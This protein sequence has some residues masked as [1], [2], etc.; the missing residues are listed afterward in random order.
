MIFLLCIGMLGHCLAGE[1]ASPNTL[2]VRSQQEYKDATRNLQPGDTIV[3]ANGVWR[4][5]EILLVGE[6]RAGNPI[7]LTAETKGKVVISGESNLRLAGKHLVVSGLVFKDGHTP[8]DAVISFRRGSKE[9]AY[10]SRVTEVVVDHFNNPERRETDFWVAMYGNHNRFDHNHLV[11]KSNVGVT[12]A[13][14][15][16]T[17]ESRKNNHRIDHNYFGPRP[18]LGSNGGETLRIGTSHH[19]LTES[20]TLVENNYF[21]RCNGELEIISNKSGGNIFRG[22][23]FFE[24]RGTLTLRH[25]SGNLVESNV[26]LGNSVDHTGGIRVINGDQTIR[27]NYMENLAGYRFGGALVVM[28]GVPDS[29]INRYHQVDNAVIENNTM[30]NADHVQLAAGSDSERSAVPINSIFRSNLFYREDGDELF[31]VFD[32]ISGIEF[33]NNAENGSTEFGRKH[34]FLGGNVYLHRAANG[35]MYPAGEAFRGI[36]V[37]RDLAPVGKE[38]TGVNWYTKPGRHSPFSGGTI[39]EVTPAEDSLSEAIALANAGDELVLQAGNYRVNRILEISRP[40]TI[41]AESGGRVR[42][43]YERSALFEIRDGGSLYLKGLHISGRAAPD[44]AGNAVIRTQRTS[45]LHNYNLVVENSIIEKLDVNHSFHFLAVSKSTFADRIDIRNSIFSNISGSVLK[46]DSESDDYGIYNAEYVS[47]SR[48]SFE[49]VGGPVIAFYRGGTDESTF[50]PHFE[51]TDSRLNSVG[52]G[53]RY[54]P[55]SS[56]HLH[57]VQV[58]KIDQNTFENSAVLSIVH[59]VG[60]PM[61]LVSDNIFVDTETP[62]VVEL[63]S[64]N[65]SAAIF[66]NNRYD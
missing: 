21:D 6:G 12:V 49:G 42:I 31:T 57:G 23:V 36:G 2:L 29:P 60:E 7:T 51:L 56:M 58:A 37:S 54:L 24:S 55:Q 26:F 28:N 11:G 52:W 41:R 33:R 65:P 35:L 3:L 9:L 18:I 5:F 43:D 64:G 20:L 45:M 15:L 61:T 66:T 46:L 50:G 1:N 39:I 17:P 53:K 63:V 27:N 30:I 25:G 47:I 10:H 22:N 48:A 59:T 13:V 32:D 8:T 4:D 14:R 44:N 34:H 19:S 38:D 16:N 40:L 62:Q